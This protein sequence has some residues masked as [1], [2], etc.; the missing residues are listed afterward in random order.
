ME[1]YEWREINPTLNWWGLYDK[2]SGKYEI[3]TTLTGME[4][5]LGFGIGVKEEKA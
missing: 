1:R 5:Y 2:V 4:V 3:E